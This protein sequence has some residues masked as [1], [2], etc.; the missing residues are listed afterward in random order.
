MLEN[1]FPGFTPS[2]SK[3]AKKKEGRRQQVPSTVNPPPPTPAR[4]HI[5][6]FVMNLPDSAIQFLDA[7]RGILSAPGLKELYEKMPMVHCHCFTREVTDPKKAEADITQVCPT[8]FRACA[9]LISC[10]GLKR[11]SATRLH[12]M[13]H[14]TLSVL[15]LQTKICT[16]SASDCLRKLRF[17]GVNHSV[18]VILYLGASRPEAFRVNHLFPPSTSHTSWDH[19]LSPHR[20]ILLAF[21]T[22]IYVPLLITSAVLD[23]AL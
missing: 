9:N 22:L 12:R 15:W 8:T 2:P 17:S 1:P 4:K 21:D 19:L 3:T 23:P 10:S 16:V 20:H 18:Y 11:N 6:H 5:S 13:F 7:F 14:F